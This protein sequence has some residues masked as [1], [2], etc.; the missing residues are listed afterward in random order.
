METKDTLSSC[1]DSDEQIMQQMLKR[2]KILN[3]RSMNGLNA[4]RTNFQLLSKTN[5]FG[6]PI[7]RGF[8]GEFERLFGE[9]HLTFTYSLLHNLNNLE[10]QLIKETLPE[11]DSKCALS[12][13]KTQCAIFFHSELL[14]LTDYDG[15]HPREILKEYTRMEAHSFK[16]LIIKNMDFIE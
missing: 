11:A 7:D 2:A 14:K 5:L 10:K 12:A 6:S 8:K 3:E 13:L 15:Q 16:E 9:E 4:L 1:S